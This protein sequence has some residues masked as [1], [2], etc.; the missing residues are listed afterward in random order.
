MDILKYSQ[1][2]QETAHKILESSKLFQLWEDIGAEVYLVGSLKTGLLIHKDID[3]HVYTEEVSIQDSFAVMAKLADRLNLTDIQYKNG[4]ETEE[5]CLE[6]HALFEDKNKDCW[7]LDL[8]HI[9]KSSMYD[10]VVERVTD[11]IAKKLTPELRQTILQIKYDMPKN[12]LIPGIEVYHA[13]FTGGVKTYKELMQWR[14]TNP[15]TDSLSWI[16]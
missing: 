3:I 16:P 13:V 15:L 14:E 4:L 6:W 5:E 9:R 8:I 12:A 10:G 11:T 7:K 2:I 1:E